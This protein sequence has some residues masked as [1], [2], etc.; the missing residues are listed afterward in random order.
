M[1]ICKAVI[2]AAG[3][4]TRMKSKTPKVIHKIMDKTMVEYATKA[5]KEAGA[6]EICVIVGHGADQVKEAIKEPVTF[7]EQTQ[8]L[9]TGHAVRCAKE[10]IGTEGTTMILFGDTP[11]IT[12][13]TLQ[14]L[15]AEHNEK[16]HAVT[17]LTTILKDST[18]YGRIIRDENGM[19]VKSVEHKDATE[20]ERNVKEVNSGMYLFNSKCLYESLD[21]LKNDNAQGE[22]YL[23]DTLPIIRSMGNNIVDAMVIEDATEIMGVNSRVQLAEASKIMRERINHHWM[24]EGVTIIAPELTFIGADVTIERDVT[25]YPNSFI[26]GDVIIRE[27]TVIEPNSK[28]GF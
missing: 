17:V 12:G 16:N 27:D 7:V 23:P 4:G 15:I 3:Q 21:L 8:Q 14:K 11:L 1:S 9:G 25:I 28:I 18:G 2:L 6:D 13:K 26:Y 5:A 20:A 10:F 19:F 24:E 22:Y